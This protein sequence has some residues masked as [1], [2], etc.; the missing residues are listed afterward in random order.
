MDKE[1]AEMVEENGIVYHLADDG[2]ET[3]RI[4]ARSGQGMPCKSGTACRT[5]D[6]RSW[7]YGGTEGCQSD[8]MDRTYE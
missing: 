6:I 3:E 1:L 2:W 4:S 7:N 5:D 8:E